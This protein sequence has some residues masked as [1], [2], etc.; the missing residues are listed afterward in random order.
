MYCPVLKSPPGHWLEQISAVFRSFPWR[1]RSFLWSWPSAACFL[2]EPRPAPLTE[3]A[4]IGLVPVFWRFRSFFRNNHAFCFSSRCVCF[5][6]WGVRF[7]R[8]RSKQSLKILV[9]FFFL[10]E[11]AVR[12]SC[13][14]LYII[15]IITL[16][17]ELLFEDIFR[18]ECSKK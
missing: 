10:G 17:N 16:F 8:H 5:L 7:G 12:G 6:P 14:T 13:M 2:S 11:D 4:P 3:H 1:F 18:C 15:I 9:F